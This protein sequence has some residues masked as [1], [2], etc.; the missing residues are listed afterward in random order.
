MMSCW[1][2]QQIPAIILV[3]LAILTQAECYPESDVT[4]AILVKQF[5]YLVD[6]DLGFMLW[7]GVHFQDVLLISHSSWAHRYEATETS[8]NCLE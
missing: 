4:T 8:Q 2:P 1:L 3:L 5:E 6:E 7:H